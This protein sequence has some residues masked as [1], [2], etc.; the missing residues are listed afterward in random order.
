[1]EPLAAVH[2]AVED[3]NR[4][5]IGGGLQMAKVYPHGNARAYGFLD[6]ARGTDVM[7]RGTRVDARASMEL[8]AAGLLVD[9]SQWNFAS[10]SFPGRRAEATRR[11]RSSPP[12][13]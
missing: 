10:A 12:S 13:V 8:E 4:R 5:T 1:M 7:V 3:R 11:K 2:N 9:L 6:S